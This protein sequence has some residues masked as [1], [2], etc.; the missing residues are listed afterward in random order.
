MKKAP[1]GAASNCFSKVLQC[2]KIFINIFLH[3][4]LDLKTGR[5]IIYAV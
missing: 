3:L 1:G 4:I 5:L 2:K